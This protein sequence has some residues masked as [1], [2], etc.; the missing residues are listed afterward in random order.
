MVELADTIDLWSIE[1]SNP[2]NSIC[3]MLIAGVVELADTRDLKSR[4]FNYSFRFEPG[5]RHFGAMVEL[6][7]TVD[8]GSTKIIL[9][10]V[11][12]PLAP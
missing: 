11:Q 5:H 4:E 1:G 9:V 3:Y 7:D 6:V 10:R 8:L 12:I 2:R